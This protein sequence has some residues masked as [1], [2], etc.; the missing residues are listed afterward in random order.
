MALKKKTKIWIIIAA[1]VAVL[2]IIISLLS[3]KKMTLVVDSD[4]CQTGSIE[5]T[6]TATGEIQPVYKVEVGTQV[7][8]IVEKMYVDYNSQVCTEDD[9]PIAGL[10]AVGNVQGDYFAN[11]YPVTCPGSSHGRSICFGRL[12]GCALARGENIDGTPSA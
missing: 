7:S 3:H 9:E 1:V 5:N 4:P 10:Y 8:G 11:S 6:V 12:V 2:I